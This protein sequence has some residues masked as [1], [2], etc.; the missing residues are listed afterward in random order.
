[1]LVINRSKMWQIFE[2]TAKSVE[3]ANRR[4]KLRALSL[5]INAFY[6]AWAGFFWH[7]NEPW[8]SAQGGRHREPLPD[9]LILRSW[10]LSAVTQHRLCAMQFAD[11][12]VL[13]RI[14]FTLFKT[15]QFVRKLNQKNPLHILP[16][17]FFKIYFN[18]IIHPS[19]GLP[20]CLFPAGL[21]T[22]TLCAFLLPTT[23]C[24]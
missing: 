9:P 10:L 22:A 6:H 14:A 8:A 17:V 20:S 21:S 11:Q 24:S 3:K 13:P 5:W 19:L 1:M 18:I 7:G 16:Y 23:A 12:V 15:A 2:K 4:R